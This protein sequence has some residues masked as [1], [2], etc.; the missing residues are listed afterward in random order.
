MGSGPLV[1]YLETL[2]RVIP[3]SRSIIL[4]IESQNV[5]CEKDLRDNL[6]WHPIVLREEENQS[7]DVPASCHLMRQ[8]V[9]LGQVIQSL[10]NS[11]FLNLAPGEIIK[12]SKMTYNY[13][14]FNILYLKREFNKCSMISLESIQEKEMLLNWAIMNNMLQL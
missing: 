13:I 1:F 12:F 14:N 5:S 11:Q 9:E 7:T 4:F 2:F 3:Y 10:G 8:E 6:T